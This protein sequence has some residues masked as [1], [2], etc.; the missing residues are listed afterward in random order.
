MIGL[1]FFSHKYNG[2]EEQTEHA[3]TAPMMSNCC[4][5]VISKHVVTHV[6]RATALN[7]RPY[8]PIE[9]ENDEITETTGNYWYVMI[10]TRV[11]ERKTKSC[12]INHHIKMLTCGVLR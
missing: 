2:E 6:D 9:K 3:V 4:F 5:W 11:V 10:I 12:P 7:Y 1:C 8:T